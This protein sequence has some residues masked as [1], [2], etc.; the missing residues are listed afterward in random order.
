M[1]GRSGSA[2]AV[3]LIAAAAGVAA[4]SYILWVRL[5]SAGERVAPLRSVTDLLDDCYARMRDLRE[6][7]MELPDGPL[8][9]AS[10]EG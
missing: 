10:A 3:G 8:R 5:R 6:Q 9:G 1:Q 2:V 7:V 4:V